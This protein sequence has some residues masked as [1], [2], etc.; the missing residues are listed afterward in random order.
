MQRVQGITLE[1]AWPK[2]GWFMTIKPALQL[3]CFVKRLRSVTSS[4]A[5]SLATGECRS[6]WLDDRYS[7]PA[8]SN[9]Q[10]MALFFRFCGSFTSMR[11]AM[12]ASGGGAID[13]KEQKPLRTETFVFTHHDLAPRNILLGTFGE[14]CLLD[15][16]FA[17]F[18]PI[19]F[20]YA[21]M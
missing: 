1:A 8:R 7:L 4:T 5:G 20:E 11:K 21:S 14:L 19:Y 17:G 10:N 12:Q 3:R 16:D 13:F 6:F 18:Y 2:L 9:S 15:W